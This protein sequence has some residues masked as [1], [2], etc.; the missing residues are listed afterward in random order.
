MVLGLEGGRL[1][2]ADCTFHPDLDGLALVG[3]FPQA[4]PYFPLVE[5]QARWVACVWAGLATVPS[6]E[7]QKA[8]FENEGLRPGG[9]RDAQAR[10]MALRFA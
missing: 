4:S 2:L 5:L 8:E 10:A 9:F 7:K 1:D 3:L 6:R